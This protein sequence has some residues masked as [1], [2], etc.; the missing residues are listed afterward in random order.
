MSLPTE[1]TPL[2]LDNNGHLSTYDPSQRPHT[3][4]ISVHTH[5]HAVL[6][7]LRNDPSG[8]LRDIVPPEA[9]LTS[10]LYVLSVLH[11][12]DRRVAEDGISV[13]LAAGQSDANVRE[14]IVRE[15]GHL[16]DEG[17]LR[18]GCGVDDAKLSRILWDRWEVKEGPCT[19]G[20]CT[21]L[22]ESKGLTHSQLWIYWRPLASLPTR[23]CPI[24]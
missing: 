13:R 12:P 20:Q 22:G 16:L 4:Q 8:P 6:S 23:S 1:S 24:R 2:L 15:L 11:T 7:D 9:E 18:E 14:R 3:S 21:N 19:C 17:G 5:A 10:L